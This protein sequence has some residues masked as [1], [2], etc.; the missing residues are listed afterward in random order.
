MFVFI[1]ESGDPGFHFERGSTRLFVFS[2]VCFTNGE[3]VDSA[4]ERV[5]KVKVSLGHKPE[6]K[7][8]KMK[9][10]DVANVFEVL[11][12]L[13]VAVFAQVIDKTALSGEE[14]GVFSYRSALMHF[15]SLL[16]FKG[17]SGLVILDGTS[18]REHARELKREFLATTF[19]EE[20]AEKFRSLTLKSSHGEI[21]L[22]VA[23]IVAGTIRRAYDRDRLESG[24]YAQLLERALG[25]RL[26]LQRLP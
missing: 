8:S 12:T 13:D 16:L 24:R 25:K 6:L 10:V 3:S 19:G 11:E 4:R 7:F 15:R 20:P 14:R 26:W 9:F 5:G 22:Q 21:L 17:V 18:G 1:D 2:A 23:D